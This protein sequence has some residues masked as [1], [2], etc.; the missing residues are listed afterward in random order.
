MKRHFFVV[1]LPYSRFCSRLIDWEKL[2][3]VFVKNSVNSVNSLCIGRFF[4]M[5]PDVWCC[6]CGCCCCCFFSYLCFISVFVSCARL[7]VDRFDFFF[8]RALLS[9][10]TDFVIVSLFFSLIRLLASD[11]TLHFSRSCTL[12]SALFP[13]SNNSEFQFFFHV[14][15]FVYATVYVYCLC[16]R[17]GQPNMSG[18]IINVLIIGHSAWSKLWFKNIPRRRKKISTG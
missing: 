4:S 13:P 12:F 7:A 1:Q 3:T 15:I 11:R 6:C 2:F 17:F 14:L 5:S 8:P 10:Q 18:Y 9:A 16:R